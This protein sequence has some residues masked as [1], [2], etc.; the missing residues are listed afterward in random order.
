MLF[1]VF[2]ERHKKSLNRLVQAENAMDRVDQSMASCLRE[3]FS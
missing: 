2:E 3:V 1:C